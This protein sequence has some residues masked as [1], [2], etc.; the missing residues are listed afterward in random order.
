MRSKAQICGTTWYSLCWDFAL[1]SLSVLEYGR[2]FFLDY[3][4]IL[5]RN[6]GVFSGKSCKIQNLNLNF[7]HL[8]T[9]VILNWSKVSSNHL[10]FFILVFYCNLDNRT[11][12]DY[13]DD[14]ITDPMDVGN[15]FSLDFK[16]ES[17]RREYIG[18]KRIL[19]KII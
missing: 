8:K 12:T 10:Y 9:I 15:E 7:K 13:H 3:F 19:K 14:V 18:K 11:L 1:P 16:P 17:S 4:L 5:I 6:I 2:V